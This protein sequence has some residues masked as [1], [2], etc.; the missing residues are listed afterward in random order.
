MLYDLI[1]MHAR[2]HLVSHLP[3]DG[4]LKWRTNRDDVAELDV[5]A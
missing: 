4:I 1:H 2:S 3:D 5:S